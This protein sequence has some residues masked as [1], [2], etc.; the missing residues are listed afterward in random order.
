[1][2][3]QPGTFIMIFA[4]VLFAVLLMPSRYP[5]LPTPRKGPIRVGYY[6]NRPMVFQDEHG[7]PRGVYVEIMTD[8][9]R[10][11]GW[12]L[13]YVYGSWEEN[14]N[15][16]ESGEIDVLLDIGY[17]EERTKR[18]D[19]TRENVFATWARIYVQKD[20]PIRSIP[21]LEGKTIAV[22]REDIHVPPLRRL[23]EDF[24]IN[25]KFETY[26]DYFAILERVSE[27]KADACLL[28]RIA[29]LV[30]ES[31]YNVERS[32]IVLN[33]I[34]I[35]I[36]FPK[37]KNGDLREAIDRHLTRQKKDQNSTLNRSLSRW[38]GGAQAGW[39]PGW[40]KIVLGSSGGLLFLF[41][42]LSFLLRSQVRAKTAQL[43]SKN[44]ALEKEMLER[45]R[46][47]EALAESEKR[48]RTILENAM[49]AVVTIDN[50]GRITGWNREAE[51]IFGFTIDEI[52][53]KEFGFLIGTDDE[54]KRMEPDIL[55]SC[56]G[57]MEITAHR[58]NGQIFPVEIHITRASL[59][60]EEIMIA[61]IRDITDRKRAMEIRERLMAMEQEL[62]VAR[63]IQ[64]SIL[65][66]ISKTIEGLEGIELFAEMIPAREVGGDFYD[67]FPI[68]PNRLGMVIGDVS[69]KGIPA[70]ILMAAAHTTMRAAAL[71][72][73]SPDQCLARANRL[74]CES[75]SPNMFVSIFFGVL[76]TETGEF[77][78]SNGGHNPPLIIREKGKVRQLPWIPGM[79]LGVVKD[80]E[81]NIGKAFV[82]PGDS[83]L[84]Y[85]DGLTEAMDRNQKMFGMKRVMESL[86]PGNG[87]SPR[88]LV[89]RLVGK[90]R[91]FTRGAEQNDDVTLLVLKYTASHKGEV[92]PAAR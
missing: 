88:M 83:L 90:V 70:A 37:G 72:D 5:A 36:A 26:G 4:L 15:R 29:G 91:D 25:C 87:S 61:F 1:M 46:A 27:K 64:Y 32:P 23:L 58:R 82:E 11:E 73:V 38:L 40:L 9:A 77:L 13:E 76:N 44:I 50:R 6:E 3:K 20:S 84:L 85:T 41:V 21:D 8:I 79:V 19:F 22:L 53:G 51:R 42:F 65:P 48:N 33:P 14:L 39:F 89:D 59:D 68:S 56:S 12:R 47:M 10:R 62:K 35:H 2:K 18:F 60:R 17:S 43:S 75:T 55:A 57:R 71:Q 34:R 45:K 86:S 78:Y 28:S 69:G 92:L 74:L 7:R 52:M 30:Q 49:Q 80:V 31:R 66:D 67:F 63:K 16:L 54:G 24:G 81:Y